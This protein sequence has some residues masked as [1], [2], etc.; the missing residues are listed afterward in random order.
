M[1]GRI[2]R[3]EAD[4]THGVEMGIEFVDVDE[5][6]TQGLI[7]EL[8]SHNSWQDTAEQAPGVFQSL[9]SFV[10]SVR[11]LFSRMRVRRRRTPRISAQKNCVLSWQGLQLICVTR[12]LSMKGLSVLVP[13]VHVFSREQGVLCLEDIVLKVSPVGVLQKGAKTI[14]RFTIDKILKGEA[15]WV[16]INRASWPHV[17]E[18]D[19]IVRVHR[20]ARRVGSFLVL[21][22][23]IAAVAFVIVHRH[24]GIQL[25]LLN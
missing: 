13:G 15:E 11:V 23:I 8:F 17:V 22:I 14:I 6:T 3:Q 20:K 9:W 2:V 4:A 21:T 25:S 12:E 24:A 16:Q 5:Q 7:Q 10:S 1:N 18:K 19:R